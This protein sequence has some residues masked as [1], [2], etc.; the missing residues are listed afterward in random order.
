MKIDSSFVTFQYWTFY[1][2]NII[3][4]ICS[5]KN[6]SWIRIDSILPPLPLQILHNPPYF[7][8]Q[9]LCLIFK[10]KPHSPIGTAQILLGVWSSPVVW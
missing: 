1:F 2:S 7:R 5:L 3:F 4:C 8:L 10:N 9:K 6:S